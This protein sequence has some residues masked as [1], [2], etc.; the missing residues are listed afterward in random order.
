M[1]ELNLRFPH[2]S[3]SEINS[4]FTFGSNKPIFTINDPFF[5]RRSFVHKSIPELV[6]KSNYICQ[7]Y[8]ENSNETLE[9]VGDSF[10][11]A[12]VSSFLHDKYSHVK[13][14]DLSKMRARIIQGTNMINI[15]K[16][17]NLRRFILIAPTV[18]NSKN[19]DRFLED[20]FEAFVAAIYYDK[21]FDCVKQFSEAVLKHY[22]PESIILINTNYKD[23]FIHFIKVF[24][25][26]AEFV[27]RKEEKTF[28]VH[29]FMNGEHYQEFSAT[30]LK[31]GEQLAAKYMISVLNITEEMIDKQRQIKKTLKLSEIH[32]NIGIGTG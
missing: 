17:M 8:M 5:Y 12:V 4:L 1:E 27:Q 29:V 10:F 21:G 18:V 16:Q 14:G 6:K 13:E 26:E 30:K 15:A 32:T 7:E 19:N 24:D 20:T 22:V 28:F 31:Q 25:I 11:S 9:M 2:V 23:V 3:E